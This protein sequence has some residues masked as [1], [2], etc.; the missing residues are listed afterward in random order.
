[1]TEVIRDVPMPDVE[2]AVVDEQDSKADTVVGN[3]GSGNVPGDVPSIASPSI[4]TSPVMLRS[5]R[6]K[7][8]PQKL[9]L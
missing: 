9:N 8:V 6:V 2:P 1:M 3:S 5:S 4:V 7:K